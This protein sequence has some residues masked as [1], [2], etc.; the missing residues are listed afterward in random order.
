MPTRG[1]TI[2]C[3]CAALVLLRVMIVGVALDRHATGGHHTVLPGDVRRFHQIAR[4]RGTPYADFSVEYPPLTLAAIDALDGRTVRQATVHLMWSQVALDAL[5]TLLLAW[6]WGQH[7]LLYLLLGLASRGTRSCTSGSI[8]SRWRSRSAGSPSCGAA[9]PEAAA[10][11]SRVACF[12]KLWPLVL[13]PDFAARR[14]WR[15]VAAFIAVGVT[16]A[17][18]WVGWAGIDGPVQVLTFRGA[19]GWQVESTIGAV[20]HVF[21]GA[22][23]HIERG[24]ARL[25]VV[26]D[27]ARLG[28][29]VFALLG[30]GAVWWLVHRRPHAPVHVVDGVA[31]VAA[32]ATLLVGRDAALTPVRVVAA[33]VRRHR[34]GRR[35]VGHRLA[36]GAGRRVEHA[37]PQP[38]EGGEPGAR[39]PDGGGTRAQRRPDRPARGRGRASRAGPAAP[40]PGARRGP[41]PRAGDSGRRH[42]GAG[43]DLLGSPLMGAATTDEWAAVPTSDADADAAPDVHVHRRELVVRACPRRVPRGAGVVAPLGR[44]GRVPQFPHRRPDPRRARSG[45]QHRPDRVEVATSPLWLAMLT[46]ARTVVPFVRIE[47]LSI[48]GGLALTGL[49]LW[50]VQAGAARLWRREG[51]GAI[52]P[53][54]AVVVA[55][56]PASWEWATSGLENGLSLAWIGALMLVLATVARAR[57]AAALD[58]EDRRGRRAA[59]PRPPGAARPHHHER[60]RDRGRARGPAPAGAELGWFLA[61]CLTLPV[62]SEL[63]RMGYYGIA[64]A[65][66]GAGE[67]RRRYVLV[68][69]LE[70]PRRSRRALLALGAD[71]H[72]GRGRSGRAGRG[73]DDADGPRPSLVVVLALPV[74]GL[75]HTLVIMK[76][77]GD[78]LHARLLMPSVFALLRRSRRCRGVASCSCR[79]SRRRV[80]GH[81][82][83]FLRPTIHEGFVPF[84]DH[85][86]VEGRDLMAGLAMP[87]HR[88][89]LAEDFIFVDGPLAKRLQ[90]RASAPW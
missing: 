88:P 58:G 10:R 25:G 85:D 79:S 43:A 5:I 47:Y 68:T 56:L 78:Y 14:S 70:L 74:A 42:A 12:A 13:A 59:R 65:E 46:V 50:W 84:T 67:G 83:A 16:G 52:V 80:G 72:G 53:L 19:K 31:P 9:S 55:A 38:R 18:A 11:W 21:A 36:H 64:R 44:G 89:I 4:H 35:G 29:P 90:E 51:G 22:G 2:A 71:P 40:H 66:H 54:G 75:L 61:G 24:A 77:G 45:F 28:L 27:W 62:L 81:R 32:V 8:S 3:C 15:A 6:G 69:G 57:P 34:G 76:S 63:F 48:V 23:A 73:R 17:A 41:V 82:G 1:R 87:D 26:P 39:A 37:R 30:V 86:I 7:A 20:V 49:G 33:P 60:R